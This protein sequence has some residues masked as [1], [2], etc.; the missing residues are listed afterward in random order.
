MREWID[1]LKASTRIY[2][3]HVRGYEFSKFLDTCRIIMDKFSCF[4]CCCGD[5]HNV[6][7]NKNVYMLNKQEQLFFLW[8]YVKHMYCMFYT[9]NVNNKKILNKLCDVCF[10]VKNSEYKKISPH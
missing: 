7:I 4:G 2:I 9:R 10:N 6:V 8:L 5:L 3:F 1:L